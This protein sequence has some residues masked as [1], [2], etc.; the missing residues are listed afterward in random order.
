M[1]DNNDPNAEDDEYLDY[2][3]YY[4][5]DE[6][7]LD[8]FDESTGKKA[9]QIDQV[10]DYT[11][12]KE[13]INSSNIESFLELQES[14]DQNT[15]YDNLTESTY[16]EELDYYQNYDNEDEDLDK[17]ANPL[18]NITTTSANNPE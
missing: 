17:L 6:E 9:D 7:G 12:L 5:N 13:N 15:E 16:N 3:Q 1:Q 4:H 8:K 11:P 14:I 10:F 2:Y 18:V